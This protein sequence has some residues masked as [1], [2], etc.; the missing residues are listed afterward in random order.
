[1]FAGASGDSSFLEIG[2]S[3]VF[4]VASNHVA[5]SN[6]PNCAESTDD[7]SSQSNP[8]RNKLAEQESSSESNSNEDDFDLS[9]ERVIASASMNGLLTET[10]GEEESDSEEERRVGEQ[11]RFLLHLFINEH[12]QNTLHEPVIVKL[13]QANAADAL[14]LGFSDENLN[15][16]AITLSRIRD[17]ILQFDL[18]YWIDQ[19]PLHSS[20]KVFERVCLRV[21]EDGEMS[22]GIVTGLFYFAY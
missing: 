6:N 10:S 4:T 1:M 9:T 16:V 13:C 5:F 15:D 22:W 20:K 2:A 14:G 19:I 21:F 12:A 18:D 3:D 17:D 11:G 8:F 7:C